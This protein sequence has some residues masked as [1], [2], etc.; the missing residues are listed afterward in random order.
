MTTILTATGNDFDRT[1]DIHDAIEAANG[2]PVYLEAGTYHI[3]CLQIRTDNATLILHPDVIIQNHLSGTDSN[4]DVYGESGAARGSGSSYAPTYAPPFTSSNTHLAA[5]V[6]QSGSNCSIIGDVAG[7]QVSSSYGPQILADGTY[8]VLM[9][10]AANNCENFRVEG[11]R[12]IGQRYKGINSRAALAGSGI[13]GK[14]YSTYIDNVYV[15]SELGYGLDSSSSSSS[16]LSEFETLGITTGPSSIQT[17]TGS[18]SL[19]TLGRVYI[20]RVVFGDFPYGY[21]VGGGP[22]IKLA[23]GSF[24]LK[25]PYIY[26]SPLG[27]K[28]G[29]SIILAENI[30]SVLMEDID[31]PGGISFFPDRDVVNYESNQIEVKSLVMKNCRVGNG[32]NTIIRDDASFT[33]PLVSMFNHPRVRNLKAYNCIFDG[34]QRSAFDFSGPYAEIYYDASSSS[35]STNIYDDF[36]LEDWEFHDCTFIS[37][38]EQSVLGS[39]NPQVMFTTGVRRDFAGK[40]K[41]YN[42]KRYGYRI[43]GDGTR[44]TPWSDN[45]QLSRAN[46]NG[47]Q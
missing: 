28:N 18:P 34:V 22:S 15:A 14:G 1:Q 39:Y 40:I 23:H 29:Y 35:S 9:S 12:C 26:E 21:S 30:T 27:S 42:T 10:D 33:T 32:A 8:S 16:G 20:G 31:L 24:H 19:G 36:S 4:G 47:I 2:R 7:K 41:H 6:Q 11:V 43:E 44:T 17:D 38:T 5:I 37:Y 13:F 3:G 25:G 46:R 45:E